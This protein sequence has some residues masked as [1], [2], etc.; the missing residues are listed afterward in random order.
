MTLRPCFVMKPRKICETCI[1][2]TDQRPLRP[3][4]FPERSEDRTKCFSPVSISGDGEPL[5]VWHCGGATVW[6][7]VFTPCIWSDWQLWP[8]LRPRGR[9]TG[10]LILHLDFAKLP[11]WQMKR[12]IDS[13]RQV[14]SNA[15]L[16]DACL[17]PFLGKHL[18]F[19]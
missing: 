11:M 7:Y 12:L 9:L 4:P 17:P 19:C 1:F 16:F 8:E 6:H 13:K 15:R 18:A 2:S 5:G 3:F 14:T 10:T